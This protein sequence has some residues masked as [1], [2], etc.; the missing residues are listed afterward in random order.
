MISEVAKFC[1][2]LLHFAT[3]DPATNLA[4]EEILLDYYPQLLSYLSE[5]K[6]QI[7]IEESFQPV[8]GITYVNRPSLIVG[9]NQNVFAEIDLK[10]YI[11]QVD[12]PVLR[13]ISGGGTVYHDLANLNYGFICAKHISLAT[14]YAHFLNPICD[15]LCGLSLPV[16]NS[17]SDLKIGKYKISGNAQVMRKHAIL[18]HGTLLYA[19]DLSKTSYLSKKSELI[20][21]R[22][23][24]SRR[25]PIKNLCEYREV[26]TAYPSFREFR[27]AIE[28]HL[29]EKTISFDYRDFGEYLSRQEFLGAA[30]SV[31]SADDLLTQYRQKYFDFEWNWRRSANFRLILRDGADIL[32]II[33]LFSD[34][35]PSLLGK[36]VVDQ[37]L[38]V[39][40]DSDNFAT[41][42]ADPLLRLEIKR[43]RVID[44]HWREYTPPHLQTVLENFSRALSNFDI[45]DLLN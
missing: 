25:A 37:L 43:G 7:S 12:M 10:Q 1:P 11:A 2:V 9:N 15:F 16:S 42:L 4:V 21:N 40:I 23:I 27:Q 30:S 5:F 36:E 3:E 26:H 39:F 45:L 8:I 31:N 28:E 14:D 19:A 18:H 17:D 22:G 34:K 24:D 41:N 13:R 32:R 20:D 44:C 33:D 35:L 6:L 29:A 38:A